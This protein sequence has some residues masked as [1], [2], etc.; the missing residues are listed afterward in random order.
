MFKYCKSTKPCE[1][2]A[3]DN[4]GV[5]KN[6]MPGF[7]GTLSFA[8]AGQN[9]SAEVPSDYTK[10]T[11]IRAGLYSFTSG[12]CNKPHQLLPEMFFWGAENEDRKIPFTT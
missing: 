6:E 4:H 9:S 5:S 1:R 2:Q 10:M 12:E 8:K 7:V 3:C 11:K